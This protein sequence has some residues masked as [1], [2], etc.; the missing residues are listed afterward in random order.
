MPLR[1]ELGS[2]IP[3]RD[4]RITGEN[5]N[6]TAHSVCG[7][8]GLLYLP[9]KKIMRNASTVAG[10]AHFAQQSFKPLCVVFPV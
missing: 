5:L 9:H 10:A 8:S 6:Y 7:I 2:N 4:T 1:A 3:T